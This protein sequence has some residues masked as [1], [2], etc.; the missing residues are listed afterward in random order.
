MAI[1]LEKWHIQEDLTSEN[2]NKRLIELETHMNNIVSRL[3]SENQ[4]LKQQ[5]N[6][7][8]EVFSVNSIN[9]DILNNANYSNNYETDTNLGKQMGLSVEWVRIKYFKH[10][11]P[12]VIGY[13][14]Q[15]AIPFEGGASLGV[16]YRNSTGNAWGAWNDMRSVEPANSNT[17][18]DANTALENGK[19]YYC[20]YKSTANI[21]YIDDGIIQ[22]FS[23]NNEKDTLTVCFQMWYSWNN[24]CVCYRKCLWGTWSPW[25]KLATTNI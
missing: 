13:G 2:F 24:D 11:N 15:I 5:L 17:I 18:T 1:N 6:N 19:I 22:V 3:E 16:F 4:Q 21:P 8:V 23:M 7:K 14:S 25:K 12:G 20:S 9:I 10:T